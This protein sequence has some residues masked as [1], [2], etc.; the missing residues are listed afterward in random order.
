MDVNTTARKLFALVA[1][2]WLLTATSGCA[3][4][5][6]TLVYWN[7]GQLVPAEFDGLADKRVAVVCVSDGSSYGTGSESSVLAREVSSILLQHVKRIELVRPDEVADWID[8]EGWDQVDYRQIG[9]GVKAEQVIAIDLEGLRIY[10][11]S[12]LYNGRAQVTVTVFDMM[13]DGGKEVF[14]KT[15][16]DFRFPALGPR[17]VGDMSE[18]QFRRAFLQVLAQHIAKHFHDYDMMDDFGRDRAFIG[19]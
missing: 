18:G 17:P 14:Q 12:S 2:G 4:F 5:W 15:V 7:K 11:G 6:S 16:H 9:R 1:I 10:E 8:R 3:G 13:V 19:G